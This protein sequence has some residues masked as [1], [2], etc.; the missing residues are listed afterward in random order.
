MKVSTRGVRALKIAR[1]AT[2]TRDPG[3]GTFHYPSPLK[4]M[5]AFGHDLVPIDSGSFWCPHPAKAGPWMLDDL[6]TYP[7]V[8]LDPLLEGITTIAAIPPDHLE[9]RQAASQRSQQHL[10]SCAIPD[11]SRQHF[12]PSSSPCVSTSRCR[13]LP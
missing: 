10:T 12:E 3:I 4:H 6:E 9:T 11:L 1:E 2:V 8:L 7:E 13:F 5:K